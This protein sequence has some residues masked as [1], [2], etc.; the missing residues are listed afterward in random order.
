M[1]KY[2][3]EVFFDKYK[4]VF[5]GK[6]DIEVREFL[7]TEEEIDQDMINYETLINLKHVLRPLISVQ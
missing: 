7:F 3:V 2:S 4:D 6:K 5:K 1:I